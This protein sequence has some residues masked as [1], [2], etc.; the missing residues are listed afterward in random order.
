M[1]V[2]PSSLKCASNEY[3]GSVGDL[4]GY[5]IPASNL[6][7]KGTLSNFRVLRLISIVYIFLD[8]DHRNL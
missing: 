1:S 7:C 3:Q 6:G 2:S 8:F 5:Y 4:Y